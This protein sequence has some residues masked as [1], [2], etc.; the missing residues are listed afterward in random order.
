MG[1][2]P[3]FSIFKSALSGARID[4]QMALVSQIKTIISQKEEA[5]RFTAECLS[6]HV[7]VNPS[8]CSVKIMRKRYAPCLNEFR[9]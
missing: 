5:V 3:N 8:R 2:K 7:F 6:A 9:D 1:R 4:F